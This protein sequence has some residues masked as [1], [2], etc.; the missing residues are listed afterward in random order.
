MTPPRRAEP[1]TQKAGRCANTIPAK[2]NP[3]PLEGTKMTHDTT[4][5]ESVKTYTVAQVK[6]EVDKAVKDEVNKAVE[7]ICG[8]FPSEIIDR[9]RSNPD[10]K[11]SAAFNRLKS[12]DKGM[13]VFWTAQA[14]NL[15]ATRADV[16]NHAKEQA[17]WYAERGAEAKRLADMTAGF[18]PIEFQKPLRDLADFMSQQADF[19]DTL[20]HKLNISRKVNIPN[21]S[22]IL[23]FRHLRDRIYE[24]TPDG[25]RIDHLALSYL[26]AAGLG[27]EFPEN[28]MGTFPDWVH[29]AL[30]KT[31]AT[32]NSIKAKPN[33]IN[34]LTNPV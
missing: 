28:E 32:G 24:Y 34:K 14:A 30:R 12:H 10:G 20:P 18:S 7:E 19:Y 5:A 1:G 3:E 9:L 6:A 26:V 4:P 25:Y 33:R 27:I 17:K 15:S 21:A 2:V 11:V 31:E 29:E 8:G 23:A 13:L 16:V 22:A